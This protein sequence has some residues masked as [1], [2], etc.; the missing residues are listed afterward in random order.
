[1]KSCIVLP[2]AKWSF[3]LKKSF[4]PRSDCFRWFPLIALAPSF[5]I[6]LSM[7]AL[8]A[9]PPNQR[10]VSQSD[11]IA[12][13]SRKID[14][15]QSMLE[16]RLGRIEALL[17]S[18]AQPPTREHQHKS[19][20]R[21]SLHSID[22]TDLPTIGSPNAPVR[23]VF[24]FDFRCG[25]CNQ[26]HGTLKA[27]RAEFGQSLCVVYVPFPLMDNGAISPAYP[28]AM[29]AYRQGRFAEMV[30]LV[31]RNGTASDSLALQSHAL[32]LKLDINRFKQDIASKSTSQLL[33]RSWK[34]GQAVRIAAVPAFLLNGRYYE[35]ALPFESLKVIIQTAIANK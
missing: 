11:S 5:A 29:A 18:I 24:F 15:L 22:I 10:D 12:V 25:F 9:S 7:P 2:T 4:K 6:A 20:A 23:L 31:Y 28:A 33:A 17:R 19:D 27:L 26:L 16:T 30:D 21:D 1:M 32:D 3:S 34:S 8:A 13:L 35:G 14:S